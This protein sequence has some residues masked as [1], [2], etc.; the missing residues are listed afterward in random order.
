MLDQAIME[1]IL[2]CKSKLLKEGTK[3]NPSYHEMR[4]CWPPTT[5]L[6][7]GDGT[8]DGE[9]VLASFCL[10]PSLA[11]F[12]YSWKNTSLLIQEKSLLMNGYDLPIQGYQGKT[13]HYARPSYHGKHHLMQVQATQGRVLLFNPSYHQ[14]VWPHQVKLPCKHPLMLDQANH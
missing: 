6:T 3:L 2:S 7:T 4:L 10:R 11:Y 13:P 1:N 8:I 5:S 14:M 12:Y 9:W